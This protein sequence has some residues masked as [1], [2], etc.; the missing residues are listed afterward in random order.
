MQSEIRAGT[1]I[2]AVVVTLWVVDIGATGAL[3]YIAEPLPI[4]VRYGIGLVEGS[5]QLA[6]S[7][8]CWMPSPAGTDRKRPPPER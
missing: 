8:S 6:R 7:T 2:D 1:I 5:S 4:V 3:L